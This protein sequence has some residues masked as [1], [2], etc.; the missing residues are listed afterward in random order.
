MELY[1][2][3]RYINQISP[4]LFVPQ[5]NAGLGFVLSLLKSFS[6][7]TQFH[8]QHFH[9]LAV[10]SSLLANSLFW[11]SIFVKCHVRLSGRQ[12]I[13]TTTVHALSS[14]PELNNRFT[15]TNHH[16]ALKEVTWSWCTSI[17]YTVICGLQRWQ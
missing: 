2:F 8:F 9:F 4:M 17:I 11:L 10:L 12:G 1:L 14:V 15:G 6:N 5:L 7:H 3:K 16:W 13:N